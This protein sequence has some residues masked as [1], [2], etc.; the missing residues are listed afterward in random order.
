VAR[1]T[2]A[3]KLTVLQKQWLDRIADQLKLETVV[4][5]AALDEGAF[6][7]KGGFRRINREFEGKLEAFLGEL[8]DEVWKDAG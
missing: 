3:H 7:A 5:R 6:A 1:V 4:D 8:V 2:K